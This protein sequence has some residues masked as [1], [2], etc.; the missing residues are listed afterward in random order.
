MISLLEIRAN[1]FGGSDLSTP[2]VLLVNPR[3]LSLKNKIRA[4]RSTLI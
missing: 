4:K 1:L 3:I 2:V